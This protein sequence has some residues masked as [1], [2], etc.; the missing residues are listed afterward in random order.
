MSYRSAWGS[1]DGILGHLVIRRLDDHGIVAAIP[2]TSEDEARDLIAR[3]EA[4]VRGP[5]AEFESAWRIPAEERADPGPDMLRRRA[6]RDPAQLPG[7]AQ[8]PDAAPDP[9][10][11][12]RRGDRVIAEDDRIAVLPDPADVFVADQPWLARVLH[13]LVSVELGSLDPAWSGRVHLLSPVEPGEGLLGDATAAH[14]DD[15]AAENWVSFRV[16]LDGR[17]RFLGSPRFFELEDREAAGESDPG[18]LRGLYAAAEAQLAGARARWRRLGALVWGDPVDPSLQREGWGTD[19][20]LVDQLGGDPGYGN[21]AAFPPP[22]AVTLDRSDPST[23]TLRL[24]DGRPFAFV[25]STAG[26][27]WRDE[28]A[29]AILLFFEPETRTAALTFDWG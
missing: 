12:P 4:G 13:P 10:P 8:L 11:A 1:S 24:A 21:W 17:Y 15:Y 5:A 6:D 2:A 25:G 26:Y 7:T 23:P 9:D 27:P 14:H 16:E 22:A 20:A 3:A 18:D 28:G 19:I 29:D